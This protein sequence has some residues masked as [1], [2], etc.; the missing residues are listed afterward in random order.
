MFPW[1][2]GIIL[3]FFLNKSGKIPGGSRAGPCSGEEG[4]NFGQE[5]DFSLEGPAPTCRQLSSCSGGNSES[6]FQID[7]VLQGLFLPFPW[8]AFVTRDRL[9]GKHSVLCDRKDSQVSSQWYFD[10][11]R[12]RIGGRVG[13]ETRRSTITIH[14]PNA[15]G[16]ILNR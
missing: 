1:Y 7:I 4:Y 10:N 2:A 15:Y 5:T 12:M 11:S 9:G 8:P 3:N 14:R 6:S 13:S 16:W